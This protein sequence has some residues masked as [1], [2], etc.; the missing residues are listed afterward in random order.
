MMTSLL[1]TF[2]C[3]H[4]C[5]VSCPAP[6]GLDVGVADDQ[7]GAQICDAT[8]TAT[9]SASP[10]QLMPWGGCRYA[11]AFV[12]G[13]YSVRAERAGFLP[14]VVPNVKVLARH[15]TCCTITETAHVEIRLSPAP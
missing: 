7:T 5:T 8:V 11:G 1:V 12:P 14:K 4:V 3:D 15:E 13:T 6:P 2:G 9:G 10:E